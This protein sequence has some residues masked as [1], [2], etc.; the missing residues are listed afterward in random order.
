MTCMVMTSPAFMLGEALLVQVY[1]KMLQNTD[2]LS[3]PP[4]LTSELSREQQNG[5]ENLGTEGNVCFLASNQFT[6][7]GY[8]FMHLHWF[9]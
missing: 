9:I 5:Q 4:S 2:Q 1:Y 7:L 6:G 3:G 8:N